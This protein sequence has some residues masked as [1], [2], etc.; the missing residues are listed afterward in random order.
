MLNISV[1]DIPTYIGTLTP[2]QL[3]A[4][5][6]VTNHGFVDGHATSLQSVLQAGTAVLVDDQGRPRVKCGCGNPLFYLVATPMRRATPA[7]PGPTS[8]R[9][10]C[11][12]SPR[13]RPGSSAHRLRH[14]H[15]PDVLAAARHRRR[16]GPADASTSG[17]D[18]RAGPD[19]TAPLAPT[20]VS[21]RG[22]PISTA[23][24]APLMRPSA[25]PTAKPLRAATA[26]RPRLCP[27]GT[28]ASD[29]GQ[30]CDPDPPDCA[31]GAHRNSN[32]TMIYGSDCNGNCPE[33]TYQKSAICV[34]DTIPTC[35][36]GYHVSYTNKCIEDCPEGYRQGARDGCAP[37]TRPA[38]TEA[39]RRPANRAPRPPGDAHARPRRRRT[40]RR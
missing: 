11:P 24:S 30:S 37:I 18:D 40:S 17:A 39:P 35:D 21:C 23:R 19:D 2:M 16:P 38:R 28:H 8:T 6:R 32:G 4:D 10:T 14:P 26:S 15:R 25:V 27:D 20:V 31:I 1:A 12:P 9:A 5:T 7:K 22:V 34:T 36:P 13:P 29:N 33:G 3:R